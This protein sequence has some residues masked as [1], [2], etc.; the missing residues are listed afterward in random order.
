MLATNKATFFESSFRQLRSQ[1][2]LT[3][4]TALGARRVVPVLATNEKGRDHR[5]VKAC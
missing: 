5:L 2:N 4:E 1:D 3:V